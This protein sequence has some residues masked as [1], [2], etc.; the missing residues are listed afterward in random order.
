MLRTSLPQIDLSQYTDKEKEELILLL[1]EAERR[2]IKL[3]AS[4][5]TPQSGTER[6][7][8]ISDNGYWPRM[9]GKLYNPKPHHAGFIASNA[10]YVGFVGSR[11]AGKSSCGAQKACNKIRDGESGMVINPDF[12]NFKIS[13]WPEFREWIP[14]NMVVPRHLYMRAPEWSPTKPFKITFINGVSVICKG[15]KDPDSA[16]GPNINWLWYDEAQRDE[17][18]RAF[19]IAIACVRVGKNPQSWVTYTPK[20]MFHWTYKMFEKKE[21][22]EDVREIIEKISKE[23]NRPIF[24]CYYGTLRDNQDNLSPEFVASILSMYP[25][26]YL[27]DREVEGLYRDEG[28][29]LGDLSWFTDHYLDKMPEL[30]QYKTIRY[31]D[32]A[33]SEKK[34]LKGKKRNDPDET[35]GTLLT[36]DRKEDFYIED[37]TCGFW[38]WESIEDNIVEVA[39][40]DGP[41]I[42][43]F[44][45]QEPGSGGKNQV[46]ALAKAVRTKLGSAWKV[47]E[48][49]PKGDKVMRA[50]PWFA[51]A[52]RGHFW[53]VKGA[54]NRETLGQIA[55]FGTAPH[56]DRVDSISGAR[57]KIA[58]YKLYKVME[59]LHL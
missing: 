58:P 57:A 39:K 26:G 23:T 55:S 36:W 30:E 34:I 8:K 27:R 18:G 28:G 52:S 22:P 16:R 44:I 43:I 38:L 15:L 41:Q 31:W 14:W 50:N 7:F 5:F 49:V 11:G 13:T 20:G 47:E 4:T 48:H 40:R 54:W 42:R 1:S 37:Q 33:A 35:V 53:I 45:E 32:L 46:A 29:S 10:L 56:D 6:K 3:P 25:P 51:E 9:D 17:T 24:D 19:Q 21:I 59:F 12:E 2:G